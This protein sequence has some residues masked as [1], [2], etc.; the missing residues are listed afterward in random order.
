[1]VRK[2]IMTATHHTLPTKHHQK[3]WKMRQDCGFGTPACASAAIVG[4]LCGLPEETR[5]E[6]ITGRSASGGEGAINRCG[7]YPKL[8]NI[9]FH[10]RDLP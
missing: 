4:A 6:W 10:H 2:A 1:M 5:D 7:T 3:V 8:V 9:L